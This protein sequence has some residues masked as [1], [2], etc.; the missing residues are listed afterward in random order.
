MPHNPLTGLHLFLNERMD[1][2]HLIKDRFRLCC[3]TTRF[4]LLKSS[5]LPSGFAA[6]FLEGHLN[7]TQNFSGRVLTLASFSVNRTY[8]LTRDF[9]NGR[10]KLL[11][12][13]L[14]NYDENLHFENLFVQINVVNRNISSFEVHFLFFLSNFSSTV[15]GH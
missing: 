15:N 9:I 12:V 14:L 8:H 3:A 11:N 2:C 10:P 7:N 6:Q 13:P 1:G 5:K 4:S